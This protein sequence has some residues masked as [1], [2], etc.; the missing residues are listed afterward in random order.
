MSADLVEEVIEA[1]G[2]LARWRAHSAYD[3][4]FSAAGLAFASKGHPRAL[5][6]GRARIGTGGQEVALTLGAWPGWQAQLV[7]EGVVLTDPS[8]RRA[9]RPRARARALLWDR[10]D[11]A[12]FCA[13]AIWTYM[14]LPFVLA[15]EALARTRVMPERRLEVRFAPHVHTHCPVQTLH[16]D[17][18]LRIIRHDYTALAFGRWARAAQL[19]SGHRRFD[20]I[21]VG[22]ER[23]VHPRGHDGRPRNRLTLV[24]I[25]I[26]RLTPSERGA[27]AAS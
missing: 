1:H 22:A 12:W 3:V 7:S 26:S 16:L 21:L 14:A 20:G 10:L 17:G 2:G 27:P 24:H 18:D 8:G 15:D 9:T 11:L 25:E 5:R 19:I 23:I 13:Q 4:A 6:H